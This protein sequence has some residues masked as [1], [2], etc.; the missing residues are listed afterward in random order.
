MTT[1]NLHLRKQCTID[2]LQ[3]WLSSQQPG[4]KVVDIVLPN[5]CEVTLVVDDGV[6]D[7]E[8]NDRDEVQR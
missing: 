7:A 3:M 5:P 6:Q 2:A 4:I 1:F 8:K